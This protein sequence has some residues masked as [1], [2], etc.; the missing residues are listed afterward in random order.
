MLSTLFVAALWFGK[1]TQKGEVSVLSGGSMAS[2]WSAG[3]WHAQGASDQ[4]GAFGGV[5]V[6]K[7]LYPGGGIK[8]TTA[9]RGVFN[10]H[11]SMEMYVRGVYGPAEVSVSLVGHQV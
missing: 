9:E 10:G 2:S 6:C 11:T 3:T 5:G 1:S 7:T 8:L 4:S